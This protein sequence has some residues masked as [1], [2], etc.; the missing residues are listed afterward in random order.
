MLHTPNIW[1]S[2]KAVW[3]YRESYV[4][5][6]T[7]FAEK[8]LQVLVSDALS[9]PSRHRQLAILRD[10]SPISLFCEYQSESDVRRRVQISWEP[11]RELNVDLPKGTVWSLEA[12]TTSMSVSFVSKVFSR[13]SISHHTLPLKG[14]STLTVS[15]ITGLT[16]ALVSL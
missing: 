12:M 16:F 9:G 15:I 8:R 5:A 1:T 10:V 6:L 11:L 14:K 3:I 13:R 4:V 7:R 2:T